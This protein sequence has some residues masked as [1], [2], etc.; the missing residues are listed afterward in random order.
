M[1]HTDVM[2]GLVVKR[3]PSG[4]LVKHND[5]NIPSWQHSSSPQEAVI[6]F[7]LEAIA[8][9]LEA[10]SPVPLRGRA[11]AAALWNPFW[12]RQLSAC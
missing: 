5:L 12:I 3:Y 9:R 10:I 4:G 7:R 8:L 11:K 1:V 2:P 6:A